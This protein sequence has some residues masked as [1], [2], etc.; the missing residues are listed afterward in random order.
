MVVVPFVIIVHT[1]VTTLMA[2]LFEKM[3]VQLTNLISFRLIVIA[4]I[5]F[6][7]ERDIKP[8]DDG[9]LRPV[10]IG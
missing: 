7:Q 4:F 10:L 3:S 1:G 9:T 5:Y 6:E 2:M 8:T